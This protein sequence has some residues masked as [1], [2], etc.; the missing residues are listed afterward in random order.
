M[1]NTAL[2]NGFKSGETLSQISAAATAAGAVFAPP[3]FTTVGPIKAPTYQE[4]NIE[5]QQAIGNDTSVS[6]NYVGNH[7][8]HETAFFNN[9]N[10]FCPASTCPNG[11]I[12]LP[13]SQPIR[14][15]EL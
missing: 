10:A 14:V 12:S 15:S 4:W 1:S 6:I 8:I 2:A 3:G 7:G 5:I 11:F 9:M 13:G